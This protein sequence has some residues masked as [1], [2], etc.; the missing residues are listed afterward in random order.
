MAY[1]PGQESGN[2]ILDVITGKVNPSGKLPFT[3]AYN[4]SDY[5]TATVNF[6]ALGITSPNGQQVN[7]S[8]GQFIDYRHFDSAGI[9]PRY[10]FGYGLSYTTFS[11]EEM[12][13]K[14]KTN[15]VS[16]LPDKRKAVQP[17]GHPDLY[18]VIATVQFKVTNTGKLAGATVPQL[19]LAFPQDTTPAGTPV[20]VLRGFE[21]VYLEA[22]GNQKVNF[23][24]TR[25][26]VSFWNVVRQEWEVPRGSF[27]A[28][29]GFSSRKILA[30]KL[31]AV[32]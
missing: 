27:E 30:N 5:N 28:M 31:F 21:K 9:T 18:E 2:A 17:G 6:T 10:E 11:I 16:P 19:Y 4:A 15:K 8:E 32:L 12:S 22:G 13:F 25:K 20:K 24:I 29:I 7:F 14:S 1:M 3:V 26:D 23:E